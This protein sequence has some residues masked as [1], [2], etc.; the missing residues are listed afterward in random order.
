MSPT[1]KSFRVVRACV[2]AVRMPSEIRAR[3]RVRALPFSLFVAL[4]FP[5][6]LESPPLPP[7]SYP[8]LVGLIGNL[9]TEEGIYVLR[10][11][12]MY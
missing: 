12:I 11:G 6:S 8:T 9:C 10:R 3:N 5:F 4:L 2:R 1:G 7:P